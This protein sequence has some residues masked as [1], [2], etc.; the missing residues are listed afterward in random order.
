MSTLVTTVREVFR[1]R[2]ETG[3]LAWVGHRLAGLGTL[4]FFMIHVIDTSFVYFWPEGYG[5]AINLYKSVPFLIGELFLLLAVI[6]HGVNG[7]RVALMDWKPQLWRY[8]RQMTLG[9]FALV[10]ALY[11]PTFIIM[12]GHILDILAAKGA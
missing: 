4:L 5:H 10:V 8:Q 2:G 3:Q 11:I 12:M 1:Y 6:Y 7:V 9:A